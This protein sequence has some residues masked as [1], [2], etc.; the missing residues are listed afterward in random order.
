MRRISLLEGWEF[1]RVVEKYFRGAWVVSLLLPSEKADIVKSMALPSILEKAGRRESAGETQGKPPVFKTVLENEIRLI[2]KEN[3]SNPIVTLQASFSGGERL[4][5]ESQNGINHLIAVMVTKG[6]E[7][8]S[9]L[10]IAKKVGRMA[11]PLTGFSG[12]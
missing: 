1:E 8:Q 7:R 10:E 9:S 11:G 12:C 6:T 4:E 2:V 5:K 3:R